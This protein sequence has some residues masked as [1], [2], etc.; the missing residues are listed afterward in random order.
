[1]RAWFD[2]LEPRERL[3]LLVAGV[4]T[5]VVAVWLI[6]VMPTVSA[7]QAA[8]QRYDASARALDVVAA[9]LAQVD[10]NQVAAGD[11]AE[12]DADHLRWRVVDS[13]QFLGLEPAQLR[14]ENDGSVSAVF[15]D[16]D[17]RLVFAYL[18]LLSTRESIIPR[19]AN[20]SRADN[21]RI[22]ASFE[23]IGAGS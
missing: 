21:G 5:L 7:N 12:Q 8:H 19:T 4:L 9:G 23:F 10:K 15:R 6:V 3:L 11:V 13:A 2:D 16:T 17:P 22:T 20:L 1:M 18:Q 14:S